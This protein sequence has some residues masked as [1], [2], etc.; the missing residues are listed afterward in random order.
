MTKSLKLCHI[1]HEMTEYPCLM[2]EKGIPARDPSLCP[3]LEMQ[4]PAPNGDGH[5]VDA[6]YYDIVLSGPVEVQLHVTAADIQ[7]YSRLYE[8]HAAQ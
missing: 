8:H 2:L 1:C 7:A 6:L 4:R 5:V 3:E